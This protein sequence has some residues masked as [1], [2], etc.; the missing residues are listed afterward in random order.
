MLPPQHPQ[1]YLSS[2]GPW[3]TRAWNSCGSRRTECF[4]W[5][6]KNHAGSPK[7]CVQSTLC[8][9]LVGFSHRPNY[10]CVQ[11]GTAIRR[12]P[13]DRVHSEDELQGPRTPLLPR[14]HGHARLWQPALLRWERG[15]RHWILQ[16]PPGLKHFREQKKVAFITSNGLPQNSVLSQFFF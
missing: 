9:A 6:G 2:C 15:A 3:A 1:W 7:K 11:T 16:H 8:F 13:V 12:A 10:A 14:L 5:C 4:C